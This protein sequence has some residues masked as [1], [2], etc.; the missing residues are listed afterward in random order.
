MWLF[1]CF[2]L[3]IVVGPHFCGGVFALNSREVG[4]V[5]KSNLERE[6]KWPKLEMRWL[7][8]DPK[9]WNGDLHERASSCTSPSSTSTQMWWQDFFWKF[10]VYSP[11]SIQPEQ[12]FIEIRVADRSSVT[13]CHEIKRQIFWF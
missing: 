10:L 5:C 13:E 1:K 3:E 2:L 9:R 6:A 12:V 4:C 7:Y 8:P 11:P